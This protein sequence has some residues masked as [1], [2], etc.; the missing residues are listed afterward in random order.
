ME[1]LADLFEVPPEENG[2]DALNAALNRLATAGWTLHS[3]SM[4][5]VSTGINHKVLVMVVAERSATDA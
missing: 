4:T 3:Q 5:T 2:L 1:Y